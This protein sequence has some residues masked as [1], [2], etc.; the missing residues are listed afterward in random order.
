MYDNIAGIHKEENELKIIR[1]AEK[2][3]L[4]VELDPTRSR[5]IY[6]P[7]L[8]IRYSARKVPENLQPTFTDTSMYT[9]LNSPL[10]IYYKIASNKLDTIFIIFYNEA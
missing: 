2:V 5:Q 1:F 7:L 10:V 6:P 4:R 9:S 8:S 3:E